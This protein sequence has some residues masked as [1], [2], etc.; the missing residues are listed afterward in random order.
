MYMHAEL[1]AAV[2]TLVA[3]RSIHL[4]NSCRVHSLKGLGCGLSACSCLPVS[5]NF[6]IIVV[7]CLK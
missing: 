3:L 4:T 5:H 1:L 6:V 2:A 7:V